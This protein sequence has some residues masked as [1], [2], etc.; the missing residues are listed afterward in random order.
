MP[1]ET[2]PMASRSKA[3]EI[4][5]C[6]YGLF[7]SSGEATGN[8]SG[9]VSKRSYTR[10]SE[11]FQDRLDQI[12]GR[13]KSK[14]RIVLKYEHQGVNVTI[15]ARREHRYVSFQA[16]PN[17]KLF[18]RLCNL[19]DHINRDRYNI[20][21]NNCVTVAAKLL[22][23][24]HPEVFPHPKKW[25]IPECFD[26]RVKT[27][28][29]KVILTKGLYRNRLLHENRACLRSVKTQRPHANGGVFSELGNTEAQ[30]NG[31]ARLSTMG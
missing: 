30:P 29:K 13:C 3:S 26:W 8:S 24:M 16:S 28:L 22:H 18:E 1:P 15:Y 19:M 21:S 9:E 27:R 2:P 31:M 5:F 23:H 11:V 4:L 10:S 12:K 6:H 17:N 25:I 14:E 20:L 7:F